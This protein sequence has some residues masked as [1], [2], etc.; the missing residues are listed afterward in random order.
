[1]QQRNSSKQF[2]AIFVTDF[3]YDEIKGEFKDEFKGELKG[4]LE[5]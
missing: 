4:E 3:G 5:G 1:M 2:Q